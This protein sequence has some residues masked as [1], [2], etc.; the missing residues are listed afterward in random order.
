MQG[1][2]GPFIGETLRHIC[3]RRVSASTTD[4]VPLLQY[5]VRKLNGVWFKAE[6]WMSQSLHR[7]ISDMGLKGLMIVIGLAQYGKRKTC[8]ATGFEVW[9]AEETGNQSDQLKLSYPPLPPFPSFSELECYAKTSS[10]NKK[11]FSFA[12]T[13]RKKV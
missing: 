6:V 10:T 9:D 7:T 2:P 5:R 11:V 8:S 4:F 12:Y 13:I 3:L 1:V